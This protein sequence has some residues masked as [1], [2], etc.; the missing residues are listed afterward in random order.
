MEDSRIIELLFQRSE[1]AIEAIEKKYHTACMSIAMNVLNNRQDAEE[2]VNDTF[3]G[4]WNSIPPHNPDPLSAYVFRIT[5]NISLNL[6]KRNTAVKRKSNYD[7]CLDE[8]ED[9]L[10]SPETVEDIVSESELTGYINE[11]LDTLDK[12]N[13]YIFVR[14]FWYLDSYDDISRA[15]GIKNGAVRIR[16][17]RVKAELKK[18]LESKGVVI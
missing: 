6:R 7:L 14:R 16:L 4:V 10:S 18:Y 3:L 5:R 11:F 1:K 9:F 13:R 8:I 12:T 17:T 15:V 2:C